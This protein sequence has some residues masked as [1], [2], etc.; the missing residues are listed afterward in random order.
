MKTLTTL[1][2][3][4]LLSLLAM[5]QDYELIPLN[6]ITKIANRNAEA[7]WGDCHPAEPIPYFGQDGEIIAWR[8]NYAVGNDFPNQAMLKNQCHALAAEGNADKQWGVGEYGRI[9]VSA[10]SNMPVILEHSG[11][12]SP[13]YSMS[14]KF[15]KLKA[16]A[17]G[18]D[19]PEIVKH[20]Y[21]GQFDIWC[22]MSNG[23]TTKYICV[24]P[25][26]GIVDD[27]GFLDLKKNKKMFCKTGD[28]SLEW[29]NYKNGFVPD[30]KGDVLVP[31]YT[32]MPFIDWSYGCSPTAAMMI[33]AYYDYRSMV[34]TSKY[35]LMVSNIFQ[36]NDIVTGGMSYTV[37]GTHRQLAIQMNTDTIEEGM[38][39]MWNVDNGMQAVTNG[40][41]GYNFDIYNK[42]STPWTRLKDEI[43]A[44]RPAIS[45]SYNEEHSFTA[46]GYNNST[47]KIIVHDTW[48][49]A[50][51]WVDKTNADVITIVKPG[52]SKETPS[53]W[54]ILKGIPGITGQDRVKIFMPVMWM[55]SGGQQI[56][57][58]RDGLKFTSQPMVAI[59]GMKL[60]KLKTIIAT[61]G[62]FLRI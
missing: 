5:A 58:V 12:L 7:L 32:Y 48:G 52:G 2:I 59:P 55:K 15:D 22:E 60:L 39:Y 47:D 16:E 46:V 40:S 35:P 23:N 62:R 51:S 19:S 14:M 9:L 54:S 1:S 31:Y 45:N 11:M 34:T 33:L 50:L 6:E 57:M 38:T 21:L 28:F 37:C 13:E 8:F 20:W 29:A 17:F 3:A 44:G 41:L 18:I 56:V 26:G 43:D 36:R 42:Y 24:S 10:R 27:A 25:T 30:T 53:I 61:T 49:P 4:I